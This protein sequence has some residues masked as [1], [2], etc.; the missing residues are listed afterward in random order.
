VKKWKDLVDAFIRQYKFNIDVNPD[1]SSLSAME[2]DKK[3]F[4][5]EYVQRW[6]EAAGHVKPSLLKMR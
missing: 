1:R 3:E 4:I 5:R 2:K 6:R